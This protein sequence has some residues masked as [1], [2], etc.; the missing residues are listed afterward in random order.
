MH[1]K[2]FLVSFSTRLIIRKF[3]RAIARE[4]LAYLSILPADQQGSIFE[5]SVPTQR[6][7]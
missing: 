3:E 5:C 6:D 4:T 1:K 2:N 7:I